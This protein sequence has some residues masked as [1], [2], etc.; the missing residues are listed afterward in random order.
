[1]NNQKITLVNVYGPNIDDPDFFKSIHHKL[2]DFDCESVIWGGDFN[3]VQDVFLDKKCG[4]RLHTHNNSRNQIHATMGA[5]DLN[6]IWREKNPNLC[7]YTW[8][9]NTNPPVQCR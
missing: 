3:C 5:Y 4:T 6:D 7:R 8:H 2:D 1:M 9:S